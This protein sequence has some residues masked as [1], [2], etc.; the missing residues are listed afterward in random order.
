LQWGQI[1]AFYKAI[2]LEMLD[3]ENYAWKT[4]EL[5]QSSLATV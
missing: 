1:P 5:Q 2:K 3:A 4:T